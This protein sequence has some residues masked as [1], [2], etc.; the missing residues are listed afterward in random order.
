MTARFTHPRLS[1]FLVAAY[2]AIRD[3][4]ASR[5]QA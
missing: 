2:I 3:W 4:L 1:P 5:I